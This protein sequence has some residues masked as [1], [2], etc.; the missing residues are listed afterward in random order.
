MT[1][2]GLII[3]RQIK[4]KVIFEALSILIGNKYV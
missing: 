4:K 1:L 3:Y 2:T